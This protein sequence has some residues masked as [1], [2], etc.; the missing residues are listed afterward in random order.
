MN[1][2]TPTIKPAATCFA[3]VASRIVETDASFIEKSLS[4]CKK[5]E[6]LGIGEACYEE[7]ITYSRYNFHS[8][9]ENSMK[10]CRRFPELWQE[11]CL[12]RNSH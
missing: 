2:Q 5:A 3:N 10:I 9:S 12:I 11:K 8:G 1:S 7:M 4:L 6:D